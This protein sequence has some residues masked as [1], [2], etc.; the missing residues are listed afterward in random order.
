M[1][2]CLSSSEE[3]FCVNSK[4]LQDGLKFSSSVFDLGLTFGVVDLYQ[5]VHLMMPLMTALKQTLQ[6][7]AGGRL[8]RPAPV[9][10]LGQLSYA[11]GRLR[12]EGQARIRGVV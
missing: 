9:Q 11:Q 2:L 7:S 8:Q 4:L 3:S 12:A 10:A 5:V 6:R 1:L